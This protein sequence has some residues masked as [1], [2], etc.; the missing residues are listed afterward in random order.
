M[1]PPLGSMYVNS[2]RREGMA[3]LHS[4]TTRGPPLGSYILQIGNAV[5]GVTGILNSGGVPLFQF[6]PSYSERPPHVGYPAW[7]VWG[8][9]HLFQKCIGK[10]LSFHP[11]RAEDL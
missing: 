6:P 10:P 8:G 2:P 4:T 7:G 11:S 9:L 3:P 5:V 1:A